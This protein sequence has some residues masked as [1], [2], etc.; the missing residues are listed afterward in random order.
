MII[1]YYHQDQR[2]TALSVQFIVARRLARYSSKAPAP[3]GNRVAAWSSA[4]ASGEGIRRV[5][6]ASGVLA[7]LDFDA[8]AAAGSAAS[9]HCPLP[10]LPVRA[11]VE[12]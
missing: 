7:S 11:T 12:R 3:Q 2:E 8:P 10:A 5:Q 4:S 9:Q 1:C 6:L